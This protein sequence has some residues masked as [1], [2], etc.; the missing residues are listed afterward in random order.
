MAENAMGFIPGTGAGA[1]VLEDLETALERGATIYAEVLGG[2]VNSGGQR[3]GG[4]MTA[5]SS[6]GVIRCI[7][8]AL[9]DSK[10]SADEVDGI[11]GHLTSTMADPLEVKNWSEAL[12]RSGKDF[13]Y[14]NALKSMIGHCL[15]AAGS[16]E[17][18]GTVLQLYNS[19]FH[20][21]LNIDDLHP[22]IEK[23]ADKSKIPQ[24]TVNFDGEIIAKASFGFGDINA[25]LILKKWRN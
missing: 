9:E 21:S 7:N 5:P 18:V 3:S 11:C 19:Y 13:P 20:G 23:Y 22:E 2:E 4:T 24:Q 12:G 25:C 10:I 1:L 15:G 17:L 16:I 8:T 14:I 6:E